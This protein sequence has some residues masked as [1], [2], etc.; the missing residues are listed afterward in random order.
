MSASKRILIV[1]TSHAELGTSGHKTG[2]WMDELAVPYNEFRR[3]G[4][5][6]DIASP[7]GGQPP[8]DPK[9][10]SG[11]N[12]DAEAFL[13]DAV[14]RAKLASTL[15]VATVE[16][17]YDAYFVAGGHG[18][19]WDLAQNAALAQLLGTAFDNGKAVAAVCHGPAA[20]IGVKLS[21]GQPLVAGRRISSFSNE[22]ETAVGLASVVPFLLET[23]LKEL[24]GQYERGPLWASYAVTDGRLVTGQNPASSKAVAQKVVEA[25]A[26]SRAVRAAS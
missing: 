13:A 21:S 3:A 5:E 2:F 17:K 23:K 6:V 8:A 14:A 16:E 7:S 25:M 19:M 15:P 4:A 10:I 24:G 12:A 22:E 9:S 18:V 1:V 26:T 11:D 20:L